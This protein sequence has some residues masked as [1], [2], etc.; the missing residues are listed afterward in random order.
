MSAKR[1]KCI[2]VT[3]LL[4]VGCGISGYSMTSYRSAIR[5]GRALIKP[6]LEIET[7][8]PKTEHMIIM[9]GAVGSDEHEWQTVSFFGGRYQLTM[10]QQVLLSPDGE[11]VLKLIGDPTFHLWVCRE[12]TADGK[13]TYYGSRQQTF[14]TDKWNS[15]RDSQFDLK[16]IDPKSDGSV[17][18]DFDAYADQW[19]ASRKVWR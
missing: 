1:F 15:F 2:V 10:S 8:F 7:Q 18:Q 6:A 4:L 9:Y 14:G 5:S 16:C 17:L 11:N 12:V 19:Q 3:L 13:G